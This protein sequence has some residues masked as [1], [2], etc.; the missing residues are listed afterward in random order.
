MNL[1]Y[2]FPRISIEPKWGDKDTILDGI[3]GAPA[4]KNYTQVKEEE[5]THEKKRKN[6]FQ[7]NT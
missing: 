7:I 4:F 2:F 5:L 6:K 3:K 1:I